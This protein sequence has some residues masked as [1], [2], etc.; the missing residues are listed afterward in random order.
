[1]SRASRFVKR[2]NTIYCARLLG[3]SQDVD[4]C[5]NLCITAQ[6]PDGARSTLIFAGKKSRG[7]R[8]LSAAELT[9]E[10]RGFVRQ[11]VGEVEILRADRLFGLSDEAFR[12]VVLRPAVV[13]QPPVVD[14]AELAR[15]LR[16]HAANV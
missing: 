7:G 10:R 9:G 1:M 2:V 12:R 3:Q 11:I 5:G 6:G 4:D 16:Q 14:A 15:R 13:V 8:P